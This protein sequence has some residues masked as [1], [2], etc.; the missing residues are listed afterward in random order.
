MARRGSLLVAL[1]VSTACGAASTS[2]ARPTTAPTSPRPSDHS[3]VTTPATTDGTDAPQAGTACGRYADPDPHRPR[4]HLTFRVPDGRRH[5]RGVETMTFTPDVSVSSVVWRL[6]PNSPRPH[7]GGGSLTVT[8]LHGS[9]GLGAFT[10]HKGDTLLRA[11]LDHRV[12]AGTSIT[13]TLHFRLTLPIGVNDRYGVRS[14][15]AW[16]GSAYPLL[17]FVRGQGY[18]TEP[19][20]A[21]FAEASTSEEFALDLTV[22]A[23]RRD[24]VLATGG[25]RGRPVR[26]GG[27]E[28]RWH[29]TAR[30]VRDVAVA[31]GRFR[32]AHRTGPGSTD[33]VV[34]VTDGMSDSPSGVADLMLAAMRDHVARFGH[35]PFG[36]L[37]VPVVP[38]VDG[39]IEYP[40]AIFLGHD[41]NDATPSHEMGHEWFYGLVGDDQARDPWLDEAFAT[42]VEALDR[43]TGPSYEKTAIPPAG[44]DKV[45]APMTYWAHHPDDYYRSVYVQGAAALLRARSAVGA[46]AFDRAIR[47]YVV[48][49]AHR[50]A[51]PGDV[52]RA[53]R[54]LPRARAILHAAG[55]F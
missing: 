47:C 36:R 8:T 43:G 3:T 31:S 16:W 29:F 21:L 19:P 17:A 22:V 11:P 55:A 10:L 7:D 27:N 13:A 14:D 53:L 25:L 28:R 4:V 48:H 24:T 54:R 52:R 2:A 26:V 49:E 39:G 9:H 1:A 42:Y 38:D 15:V 33:I 18:A 41:Q 40:G 44:Q 51:T 35:F 37:V 6:W 5:I 50:V 46:S 12:P 30:S 34:G 23:P 32:L 20:T 45:G